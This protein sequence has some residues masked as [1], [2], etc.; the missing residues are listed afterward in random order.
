MK[1]IN[2][3]KA[4]AKNKQKRYRDIS[5]D[6]LDIFEN[7]DINED[8]VLEILERFKK[9]FLAIQAQKKSEKNGHI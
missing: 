7:K 2:I 4:I 5:N 1:A 8:E 6:I 9:D 3:I